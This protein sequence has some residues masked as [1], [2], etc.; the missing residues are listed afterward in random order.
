VLAEVTRYLLL[1]KKLC[2]PHVGTFEIVQQSPEYSV[3]DKLIHPPKYS[4]RFF[5]QEQLSAHQVDYLALLSNS[6]KE[7]ASKELY[8]LGDRIRRVAEKDFFNWNGIGSLRVHGNSVS[9]EDRMV[10]IEGLNTVNAH[11]VLRE[12]VEHSRLVGDRQTTSVIKKK[13]FKKYRWSLPLRWAWIILAVAVTAILI[14]L[15]VFHFNPLATG[16]KLKF[17]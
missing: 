12:N 6:S 11:K 8:T 10:N 3:V 15:L 5:Q 2:I 9:F 17:F 1:Y 14:L 7:S 13:P 16:L 4:I